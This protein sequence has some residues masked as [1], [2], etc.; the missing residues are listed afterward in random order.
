MQNISI[1]ILSLITSA[2][3]AGASV[4]FYFIYAKAPV[5][6]DLSASI[7]PESIK[8]EGLQRNY[9]SYVQKSWLLNQH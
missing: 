2:F 9:L 7:Q 3:A 1:L 8:I 6:P 5:L 4:Y